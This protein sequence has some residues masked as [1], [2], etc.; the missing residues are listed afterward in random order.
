MPRTSSRTRNKPARFGYS[1]TGEPYPRGSALAA[2]RSVRQ[3]GRRVVPVEPI[4]IEKPPKQGK[5]DRSWNRVYYVFSNL[6]DME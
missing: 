5:I 2:A 6:I 1:A 3:P 4:V